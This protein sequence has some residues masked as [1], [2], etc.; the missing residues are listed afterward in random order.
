MSGGGADTL[1]RLDVSG[2]TLMCRRSCVAALKA[3]LR[4]FGVNLDLAQNRGSAH[5]KDGRAA[6]VLQ[7]AREGAM[8]EAFLAG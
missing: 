3:R 5:R 8:R 4:G 6:W 1:A 7:R 2:R